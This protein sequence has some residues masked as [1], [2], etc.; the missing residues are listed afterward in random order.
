MATEADA[1]TPLLFPLA[2]ATLPPAP[3][4]HIPVLL[5][6]TSHQEVPSTGELEAVDKTNLRERGHSKTS[7][8]SSP[9]LPKAGKGLVD[10]PAALCTG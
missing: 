7:E 10:A 1:H 4:P 6:H 9:P 2:T 8:H 3:P 5:S